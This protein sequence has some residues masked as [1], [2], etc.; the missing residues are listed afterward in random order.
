VIVLEYDAEREL[1]CFQN[2]TS[3]Y[4]EFISSRRRMLREL[5]RR[6]SSDSYSVGRTTAVSRP[7]PL[8]VF[9]SIDLSSQSSSPLKVYAGLFNP[10]LP[11]TDEEILQA[12]QEVQAIEIV[13][14]VA[15]THEVL[16]NT[17]REDSASN[18][19]MPWYIQPYDRTSSLSGPFKSGIYPGMNWLIRAMQKQNSTYKEF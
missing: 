10:T 12:Q 11:S 4:G 3:L 13:N 8:L 7:A 19:S 6:N 16:L 14:A 9:L 15:R 5:K 2:L 1:Q 17:I 18:S